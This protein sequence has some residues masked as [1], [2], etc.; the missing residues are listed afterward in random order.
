MV[1]GAD[2]QGLEVLPLVKWPCSN[3]FFK[4]CVITSSEL[5]FYGSEDGV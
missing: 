4:V 3:S 1:V 5:V 2:M